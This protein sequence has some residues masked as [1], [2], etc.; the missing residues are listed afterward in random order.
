MGIIRLGPENFDFNTIVTHPSRSYSSSSIGPSGSRG[1]IGGRIPSVGPGITGS[2]FIF[3][4]RSEA[5]KDT[6]LLLNDVSS[7][8]VS[9][10]AWTSNHV[11]FAQQRISLLELMKDIQAE[12]EKELGP[13]TQATK[14]LDPPSKEI[15]KREA[16]MN[17]V[18]VMP[19]STRSLQIKNIERFSQ[20]A[21]IAAV[22]KDENGVVVVDEGTNM[23]RNAAFRTVQNTYFPY[24]MSRLPGMGMD[25]RNYHTLNFFTSSQTPN[26]AV[27]I[28]PAQT[29]SN[30][31]QNNEYGT[32]LNFDLPYR[33]KDAFTFSFYINPRYNDAFDH[34]SGKRKHFRAGTIF[35]MSSCY[36]ISL[37]TGSTLGQD[38]KPDTFRIML[39]LSH[40]ADISPS[41]FPT[42]GRGYDPRRHGKTDRHLPYPQDLVFLS[43]DSGSIKY[44]HWHHIA[45]TWPGFFVQGGTGSIYIDNKLD[46]YFRPVTGRHPGAGQSALPTPEHSLPPVTQYFPADR[47]PVTNSDF[48]YEGDFTPYHVPKLRNRNV[49]AGGTRAGGNVKPRDPDALFIGNYYQGRNQTFSDSNIS[50]YFNRPVGR[51]EGVHGSDT[52][53]LI[54]QSPPG[55]SG[56]ADPGPF[57]PANFSHPLNAEIHDLRIYKIALD[58]DQIAA[59][60][61]EG[62]RFVVTQSQR[63]SFGAGY[64]HVKAW[65]LTINS[66]KYK[67]IFDNSSGQTAMQAKD[68]G[69]DRKFITNPDLMLYIP[70][71]FV[72]ESPKR[73]LFR[74]PRE[75]M[76]PDRGTTI[77]PINARMSFL[78]NVHDISLPNF[79]REFVQMKYP[80]AFQMTASFANG[81]D[82]KTPFSLQGF[83]CDGS[84]MMITDGGSGNKSEVRNFARRFVYGKDIDEMK[85]VNRR[86][87]LIMPNDNGLFQPN[88]TLLLTGTTGGMQMAKF[89]NYRRRSVKAGRSLSM[90]TSADDPIYN[91]DLN[92]VITSGSE[93]DRFVNSNSKIYTAKD[94]VVDTRYRGTGVLSAGGQS[95]PQDPVPKPQGVLD[96]SMIDLS[97]L[98]FVHKDRITK[99]I[100]EIDLMDEDSLLNTLETPF[101]PLQV[102]RFDDEGINTTADLVNGVGPYM[103][104]AL[105]DPSSN[106]KTLFNIPQLFYGDRIE[107][108]SMTIMGGIG[109]TK[110]GKVHSDK[111]FRQTLR[112]TLKDNGEGVLYRAD[113]LTPHAKWNKVGNVLYDEGLVVILSPHLKDFGE[114]EHAIDLRGTHN[115]HVLEV[116]IPCPAGQINSS[117]NPTYRRLLPSN[118]LFDKNSEFVYIT[119]L[120]LHDD[121]FNVLSRTNLA[122]PVVKRSSDKLMF[123]VKIDF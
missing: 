26:D 62:P 103:Y 75:I 104:L 70:P 87:L 46:S 51:R 3:A 44:N 89:A 58:T 98:I 90:P 84:G 4:E 99:F 105:R 97:D 38:G 57:T 120:S 40:S 88:F 22:F 100:T 19:Q 72:K 53:R 116:M 48:L 68:R 10:T 18:R 42:R 45:I 5:I 11:Q 106:A 12:S 94:P 34:I 63:G 73:F 122:Q 112:M 67:A 6:E 101:H 83:R 86:Q 8:K 111:E 92:I 50:G 56:I 55:S 31:M 95:Q 65:Q 23:Q 66:Q 24:Y 16:M 29:M 64:N 32:E 113:A 74:G 28:Y 27:L 80:R 77:N 47:N 102:A 25:Y 21:P 121:N 30:L 17:L 1:G 69:L 119:G 41:Q 115:I 118:E 60:S 85:I 123:R 49:D 9:A 96:L 59:A 76:Y 2:V 93:M 52:I 43:T 33:P 78:T 35:H 13:G 110:F 82:Y 79:L 71:F 107:G 91:E 15:T 14:P 39:Q 36:A 114:L 61:R 7:G 81:T 37:V 117:S 20:P 108:N 54:P 109:T